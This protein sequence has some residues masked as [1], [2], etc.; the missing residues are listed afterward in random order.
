MKPAAN[1]QP[2]PLA[3]VW[4][5]NLEAVLAQLL[6]DGTNRVTLELDGQPDAQG[7]VK[8][9]VRPVPQQENKS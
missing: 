5:T 1:R 7:R 4:Q 9:L 2:P 8:L 6:A 3:H